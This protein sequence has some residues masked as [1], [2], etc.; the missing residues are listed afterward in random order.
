MKAKRVKDLRQSFGNVAEVFSI[1]LFVF[2]W[3]PVIM[4]G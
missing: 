4:A 2:T 3:K 1:T